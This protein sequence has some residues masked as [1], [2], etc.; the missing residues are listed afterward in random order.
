MPGGLPELEGRQPDGGE[1]WIEVGRQGDVVEA[2]DADVLRHAQLRL[3]E[4]PDGAERHD[5]ARHEDGRE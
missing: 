2:D 3:A 5:V 4:C 1:G